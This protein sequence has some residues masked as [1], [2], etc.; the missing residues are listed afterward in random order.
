MKKIF[1]KQA[2][3]SVLLAVFMIACF[4][5]AVFAGSAMSVVDDDVINALEGFRIGRYVAQADAAQPEKANPA[6]LSDSSMVDSEVIVGLK[7]FR[8][9]ASDQYLYA[10]K[11][12]SPVQAN[13]WVRK[14]DSIVDAEL[15][16][17]LAEFE[18]IDGF[19]VAE[20][21]LVADMKD[22]FEKIGRN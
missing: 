7:D 2:S 17:R 21:K 3:V 15:I 19:R 20:A 14:R 13:S 22:I 4:S 9:G 1:T 12:S 6:A 16:C 11:M 8:F 18:I 5:P 10:Q